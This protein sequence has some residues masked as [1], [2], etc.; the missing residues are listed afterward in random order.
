MDMPPNDFLGLH[1]YGHLSG[2][3]RGKFSMAIFT[4]S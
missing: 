1:R 3:R 4:T 2:L